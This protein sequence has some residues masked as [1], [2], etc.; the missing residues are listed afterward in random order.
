MRTFVRRGMLEAARQGSG[1]LLLAAAGLHKGLSC[2]GKSRRVSPPAPASPLDFFLGG[3]FG[4]LGA[5]TCFAVPYVPPRVRVQL[6]YTCVGSAGGGGE[7]KSKGPMPGWG[8]PLGGLP[9]SD[10]PPSAVSLKRRC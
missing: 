7:V 1:R 3:W 4:A 10:I 6:G 2:A 8:V 5:F 9:L